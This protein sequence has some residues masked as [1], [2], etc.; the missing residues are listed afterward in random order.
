MCLSAVLGV[1]SALIGAGS[2]NKAAKAQ[3]RAAAAQA[4]VQ[5]EMYD[6]TR[7]DLAP[8]RDLGG[9]A[10]QAINYLNGFGAAPVVGGTTP[11]I[12]SSVTRGTPA[13]Y[14]WNARQGI[15]ELVSRARPGSTS[16]SVGGNNFNSMDEA[17]A[18]ANA[19]PIGGTPWE[20]QTDPGYQFRLGEGMRAVEAG[21]ARRHGLASGATM[22][23][24]NRSAQGFASNEYGNVYNRIAGQANMGQSAA[25]G[26]AAANQNY[27]TG[28]SNA[29]ANLGDARAAGA[30]GVGNA[31]QGG[32]NNGLGIWAYGQGQGGGGGG[33]G[34]TLNSLFNGSWKLT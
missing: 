11:D 4:Q 1:G 8:Y 21:A 17:E 2:A 18:Y 14:E 23:A 3:E 20:W 13:R 32:I 29:L 19:N 16:Y 28:A 5:R 12:T 30:I 26:T 6:Q 7:T 15:N 33:F 27:A 22:E 10:A 34:G 9:P 31:L 24:L 25:A